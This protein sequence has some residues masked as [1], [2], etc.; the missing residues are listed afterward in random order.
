MYYSLQ[1]AT[2][3]PIVIE[4][5]NQWPVYPSFLIREKILAFSWAALN[6]LHPIFLHRIYNLERRV[7][8]RILCVYLAVILCS[9]LFITT[10]DTIRS[11]GT[12]F[13]L[14][15]TG[16]GF[17]NLSCHFSALYHKS[18]Y[19]KTFSFFGIMV[20]LCAIHDG[21]TY[22]S[23]YS[24]FNVSILGYTP[25]VM[26]FHVGA[27]FLYIGT[28][29]ILVSKFMTITEE[30]EAL[31]ENLENYIFENARLNQKLEDHAFKKKTTT[32]SSIAEE[33]IKQVIDYITENYSITEL[34]REELASKVGVHPDSFGRQFKL[35]T[36][37]KLGDF[38]YEI[39]V[40]EAA[41]RLREDD[42]NVIDIAF[43]VGFESVRTFNRI[44]PKFMDT[45]PNK[46]RN[47]FRGDNGQETD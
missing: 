37:K 24:D 14:I 3:L 6:V 9:C 45:T 11:H 25:S 38:I 12:F 19:S 30:V 20:V 21:L 46:Y 26:I 42:S 39:R 23:K 2:G 28:A 1:L 41:R 22:L 17:Y 4:I 7:V 34:T 32:I 15:T 40:N 18:P 16:I 31:N 43:D 36:G 35:Y 5:C 8:E 27:I 29:F 13:I 33:K 47:M 44:F 10:D